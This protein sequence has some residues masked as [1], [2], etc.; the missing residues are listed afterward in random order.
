MSTRPPGGSPP[1]DAATTGGRVTPL[2]PVAQAICVR[3]Q[4]EYPDERERYGEAGGAWCVHDNRWLLHWAASDLLIEDHLATQVLWLAR[5]LRARDFPLERLRRNLE[6]GADVV[7][8]GAFG[9]DSAAIATRLRA[10]SETVRVFAAT[11]ERA[12]AE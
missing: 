1:P 12:P 4:A 5:V 9:T 6:I 7:E 3:Y 2:I 8:D 11:T 10:A